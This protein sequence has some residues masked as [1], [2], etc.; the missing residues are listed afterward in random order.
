MNLHVEFLHDLPS[1]TASERR[2]V[3]RRHNSCFE[4]KVYSQRLT[5]S[6]NQRPDS[7]TPDKSGAWLH[8]QVSVAEQYVF[9]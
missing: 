5:V 3:I 1:Q 7:E 6:M 4:L 8:F 9:N 2:A